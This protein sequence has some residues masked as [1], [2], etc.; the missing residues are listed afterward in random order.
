MERPSAFL[1]GESETA[2]SHIAN[3]CDQM[4]DFKETQ[5]RR[6]RRGRALLESS[7]VSA[8]S[9][10]NDP[11]APQSDMR[12]RATQRSRMM[13]LTESAKK[14]MPSSD[15]F[16]TGIADVARRI[17]SD[18]C[19]STPE[20][21]GKGVDLVD[22]LLADAEANKARSVSH[23]FPVRP[24]SRGER[25]SLRTLLPASSL[26]A[27]GPSLSI[28]THTPRRLSTPLLTPFNSTPTLQDLSMSEEVSVNALGALSSAVAPAVPGY[29]DKNAALTYAKATDAAKTM[30]A[31]CLDRTVEGEP[32]ISVVSPEMEINARRAATAATGT[33]S[34]VASVSGASTVNVSNDVLRAQGGGGDTMD[35][36]LLSMN[37]DPH[38]L[39][40][41]SSS[42]GL[43]G[44]TE[45][46]YVA[47]V[48][49]DIEIILRHA[50]VAATES[51]VVS[52]VGAGAADVEIRDPAKPVEWKLAVRRARPGADTCAAGGE[53]R[54]LPIR[55]R[56]RCE[57][58]SLRTFPV[59]TLHPRFPFNV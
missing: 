18:P 53:T 2:L 11:C 39:N 41:Q 23:W 45:T 35:M 40:Q 3:A 59:V 32:T 26:S 49:G 48:G 21:R 47:S 33:D 10:F 55:P 28:P 1:N 14:T 31:R 52:S 38:A 36:K 44:A 46:L 54:L 19:E 12:D 13:I 17:L 29:G 27:Q 5:R 8:S 58:R 57:R 4:L 37:F 50:R 9:P 30:M 15:S 6:R 16:A 20:T 56:S 51:L 22:T 25:R 7:S 42:Y 43:N 24:R 34:A